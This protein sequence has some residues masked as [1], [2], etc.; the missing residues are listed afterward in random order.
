M[1]AALLL[2]LLIYSP[3]LLSS[4]PDPTKGNLLTTLSGW[5]PVPADASFYRTWEEAGRQLRAGR[6]P[7][8]EPE[9]AQ[10]LL[11]ASDIPA[12]YPGALLYYLVG[13]TW[14]VLLF[15]LVH[16]WGLAIGSWAL[17]LRFG[18]TRAT[19]LLLLAIITGSLLIAASLRPD[20]LA[21]LSWLPVALWLASWRRRGLALVALPLPLALIA[22]AGPF[23]LTLLYW[24]LL[25][26]TSVLSPQSSV[27]PSPSSVLYLTLSIIAAL[28]IAGPQLFPRLS[29]TGPGYSSLVLSSS[30]EAFRVSGSKGMQIQ[31]IQ[32]LPDG[33]YSINLTIAAG[34][35]QAEIGLQGRTPTTATSPEEKPTGW[36]GQ[37]TLSGSSKKGPEVKITG[38]AGSTGDQRISIK[39][40]EKQ[41]PPVE[42]AYTLRLRYT[43]LWFLL[44][45]YSAFLGLV[46]LGLILGIMGWVRF[47]RE[48]EGDHP[49]RRVVKNSATPL[50]AQLVGKML[51][52]GFA[53]FVLRLLGP[54][55]NGQYTFAVTTWVFFAAF[56]D[57]GLEG[58]VTR[59][60]A[61]A[62]NLPDAQAQVNRLFYTK[63]FLRLGF[64]LAALP[65]ALLWLGLFGLSG[66]L[67]AASVW[68]VILLMLGFWPSVVAGSITVVFRGYEKFEYLAAVQLLAA[69][70]KVPLGLG[71]LLAGWGPVGLAASSVVVNVIQVAVLQ[72]LLSS[73][74]FRPRLSRMSFDRKLAGEL[75][76]QSFPLLLNGLI[77]SILF[78]SDGLI[79]QAFQGNAQLGIY[80]AAY[81]FIDALLIIPST[82]T[83]ALFP[84]FSSYG[85]AAKDNLLR[86]YREG[87]RLLMVIAWPVSAGTLFVAYDVIGVLGGSDYLPDGAIALQI[88]I[89]FLP[90]SY[91]NGLT[92]YVLIAIDKQRSITWAVV[93]AAVANIGLNLLLIPFFG[94]IAAAALTILTEIILLVP[95]CLIMRRALGAAA[96]PLFSTNWRPMLA[97]GAMILVLS[98][99]SL[100]GVN[101]FAITVVVGAAVYLVILAA[102]KAV[103]KAD[104]TLLKKVVKR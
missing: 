20:W 62:R 59:E 102:T 64:S 91:I 43:P 41:R 75:L 61:R 92:Q 77:I 21:A 94:Y 11:E 2:T 16:F 48:E 54:E 27:L 1:L 71:A 98:G 52:F 40:D 26:K 17:G 68:A 10:P 24:L 8:W 90:F 79:L 36:S 18:K 103:T 65:L 87:L 39:F 72:S 45:I 93:V 53:I 47:Y 32:P 15:S 33:Q 37:L 49:L 80:N 22:L 67:S 25:P 89:W 63:L 95:F 100:V 4:A 101:N 44:G 82:L 6:I 84:L 57:F 34:T 28:F 58:I 35:E 29:Y 5:S 96:V 97:S 46:S 74:I 31:Q 38:P 9:T 88:L 51:D 99:L 85:T 86:A 12:L 69:V 42:T 56:C 60:V 83:I 23:P 81:K 104:L 30:S 19:K 76:R 14:G 3:A 7:L 66:N 13:S 78:K 50:F 55:G 73:Q 70:V